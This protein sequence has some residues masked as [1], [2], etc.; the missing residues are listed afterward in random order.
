MA[1]MSTPPKPYANDPYATY[2]ET[3]GPWVAETRH[4][5][6]R[7]LNDVFDNA[8][9]LPARYWRSDGRVPRWGSLGSAIL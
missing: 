2:A 5:S 6:R 7:L 9:R 3:G 8:L 1:R 4:A